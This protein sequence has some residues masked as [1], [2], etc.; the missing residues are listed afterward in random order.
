MEVAV[1]VPL[2]RHDFRRAYGTD[3]FEDW[4]AGPS[5]KVRF[6][7]AFWLEPV[8][9]AAGITADRKRQVAFNPDSRFLYHI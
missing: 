9:T 8:A 4:R 3:T 7:T 6:E 1:Q 2:V 5:F